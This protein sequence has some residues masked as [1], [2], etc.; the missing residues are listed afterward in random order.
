VT[1]LFNLKITNQYLWAK[2]PDT[3]ADRNQ[4]TLIFKKW[5]YPKDDLT[6]LKLCTILRVCQRNK[7]MQENG[8]V[9]LAAFQASA[10]YSVSINKWVGT[11][12][13]IS[14]TLTVCE[15]FINSSAFGSQRAGDFSC[16]C[17]TKQRTIDRSAIG[18]NT[19]QRLLRRNCI[20]KAS[21]RKLR[22]TTHEQLWT[23][24]VR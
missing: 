12:V 16:W 22:K 11:C 19:R 20:R 9:I 1:P 24:T 6:Y 18:F 4:I 10:K 3:R 7:P 14:L 21:L 8:L 2:I 17:G 13:Q 15:A 23:T 5:Q